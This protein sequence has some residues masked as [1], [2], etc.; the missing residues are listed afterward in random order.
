[1]TT[2]AEKMAQGGSTIPP[3]IEIRLLRRRLDDAVRYFQELRALYAEATGVNWVPSELIPDRV[4]E[5]TLADKAFLSDLGIK[6]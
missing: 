1:M 3:H 2:I 6:L 4:T 5:M